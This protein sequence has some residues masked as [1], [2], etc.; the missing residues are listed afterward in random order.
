MKRQY[1]LTALILALVL[2]ASGCASG[3]DLVLQTEAT[4]SSAQTMTEFTLSPKD[5]TETSEGTELFIETEA[6]TATQTTAVTETAAPTE[7]SV[8]LPETQTVTE[9]TAAATTAAT[10]SAT[11]AATTEPVSLAKSSDGITPVDLSKEKPYSRKAEITQTYAYRN[12]SDADKRIYD[13]ILDCL[14]NEKT[15]IWFSAPYPTSQKV[16]EIVYAV[17]F[18]E[19]LYDYIDLSKCGLY[20]I[21]TPNQLVGKLEL[22]YSADGMGAFDRVRMART[23]ANAI[24]SKITPDM[25]EYEVVEYLYNTV[26]SRCVYDDSS[27]YNSS[28]YG[29]LVEG[30]AVCQGYAKTMSL[31]LNKAGIENTLI[32]GYASEA[33]MWNAV[34]IEGEWYEFDLTWD[35]IDEEA[36]FPG[37]VMYDYFL[38]TSAQMGRMRYD[39]NIAMP[40]STGTKYNYYRRNGV[41]VSSEDDIKSAIYNATVKAVN[42][43]SKYVQVKCADSAVFDKA[44]QYISSGDL[45]N[46]FVKAQTDTGADFKIDAFSFCSIKPKGW[47]LIILD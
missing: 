39:Y 1:K 7:T 13:D 35:D 14:K 22:G 29:V 43:N 26:A 8:T 5:I 36:E 41:L 20:Y 19:P 28:A 3:G 32:M 38:V 30:K 37:L 31:L 12:L 17:T 47:I 16:Q 44:T 46:I 21:D 18:Y 33:H 11:T 15:E 23:E 6:T 27:K 25:S 9:T 42:G 2:M 34:M 10:T 4:L 40:N 24:V 45:R